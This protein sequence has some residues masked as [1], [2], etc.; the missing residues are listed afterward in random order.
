MLVFVQLNK[1]TFSVRLRID[2][3]VGYFNVSTDI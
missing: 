3:F 2:I 1:R